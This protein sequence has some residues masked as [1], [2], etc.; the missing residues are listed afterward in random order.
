MNKSL[1]T[2]LGAALALSACSH[3]A[4]FLYRVDITQGNLFSQSTVEQLRPGMTRQQARRL[5]GTP[6]LA[7]PFRNDQDIYIYRFSSGESGITYR[8]DLT[9]T[10][11]QNNHIID[12]NE[13]ALT[14]EQ[15]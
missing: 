10:Y 2:L 15:N 9:I 1:I 6:L 7:D 14:T 5:L 4:P 11:D 8:K 13:T 12:I 3:K